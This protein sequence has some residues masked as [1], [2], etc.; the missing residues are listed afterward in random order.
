MLIFS[1]TH[2]RQVISSYAEYYNEVRTHLAAPPPEVTRST[3]QGLAL[4]LVRR[5]IPSE[6]DL[7]SDFPCSAGNN[8]LLAPEDSLFGRVENLSV[9]S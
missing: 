2:L 9:T 8:T 1:E 5:K 7:A 3:D 6:G 4:K